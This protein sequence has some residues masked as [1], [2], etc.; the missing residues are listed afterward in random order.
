M[1]S[2]Q[3]VRDF[4]SPS[5][6]DEIGAL[7]S[8][9]DAASES[10]DWKALASR[11]FATLYKILSPLP[12][13]TED[14]ESEFL[15]KSPFEVA[16]LHSASAYEASTF[17]VIDQVKVMGWVQQNTIMN[18]LEGISDEVRRP[19]ARRQFDGI[20]LGQ[21]ARA[22]KAQVGDMLTALTAGQRLT[23]CAKLHPSVQARAHALTQAAANACTNMHIVTG[24]HVR[25]RL[26]A[27][28]RV[29][30]HTSAPMYLLQ[31]L[32]STL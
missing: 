18:D 2:F 6:L 28:A 25:A 20:K 11:L 12:Q 29:L 21:P 16:G 17:Y 8:D 24:A 27:P 14:Q 13:D 7:L 22:S 4:L 15:M 10:A 1:V 30:W 32:Q 19:I 23:H 26:P 5:K 31:R 9:F 3:Q